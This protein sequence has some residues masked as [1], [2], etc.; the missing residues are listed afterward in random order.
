MVWGGERGEGD[1]EATFSCSS[2]IIVGFG[3][4]QG[5][6]CNAPFCY[7]LQEVQALAA[8]GAHPNIV[9]YYSAWAEPDIQVCDGLTIIW[10]LSSVSG[11]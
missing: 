6:I 4:T 7:L 8:V 1:L 11:S 5:L 10:Q 2:C 9:Q 3:F